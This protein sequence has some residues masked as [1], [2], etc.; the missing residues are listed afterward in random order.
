MRSFSALLLLLVSPLCM[1]SVLY[2]GPI[3]LTGSGSFYDPDPGEI[4]EGMVGSLGLALSASGSNGTD[5]VS[6]GVSNINADN[7]L[8][9]LGPG[10]IPIIGST[11]GFSADTSQCL[12]GYTVVP[13]IQC[14]ATIDGITGIGAF[15]NLGGGDGTVQVFAIVFFGG[16]G[17]FP[18]PGALLA[19][20]E[21][22]VYS[23]FTSVL[24]LSADPNIP[25]F[26]STFVLQDT[27]EPSAVFTGLIGI[28]A[29]AVLR[30]FYH[31]LGLL[32]SLHLQMDPLP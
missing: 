10:L 21:V 18:Q 24:L 1:A 30:R 12:T 25:R 7:A 13:T 6:I 20:A 15:T 16:P 2:V 22:S 28:V 19:Q 3:N 26:Q 9:A 8:A 14:S 5:S 4:G 29:F 32:K 27:P 23:D 31:K 11:F 17:G